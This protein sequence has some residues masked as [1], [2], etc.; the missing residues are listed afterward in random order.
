DPHHLQGPHDGRVEDVGRHHPGSAFPADQ[1]ASRRRALSHI[2]P[3]GG[4]VSPLGGVRGGTPPRGV[5]V[6]IVSYNVRELLDACLQSLRVAAAHLERV[7][8]AKTEIII[9]DNDSRDGTL[10]LLKPR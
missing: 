6:V 7:R 8:G 10:T 4:N 1:V 5:S 3:E 2:P 9:F